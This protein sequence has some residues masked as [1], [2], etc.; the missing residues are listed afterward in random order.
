MS[1]H[2]S[3]ALVAGFL[4][5]TDSPGG[6]SALLKS[7]PSAAGFWSHGRMTDR[8][9]RFQSGMT[10]E[11]LTAFHG[12]ALL[13]WFLADSRAKT[14]ARAIPTP[15]ASVGPGADSGEKWPESLAKFDPCTSS[16][17]TRPSSPAA[18][19]TSSLE[20]LPAWGMMHGGELWAVSTS[21][22]YTVACARGL[23]LPTPLASDGKGSHSMKGGRLRS[24]ARSKDGARN[25]RDWCGMFW[26]MQYPP[27]AAGEYVMGWPIGWTALAPLETARTL[28]RCA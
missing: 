2:F 16:W 22:P 10:F 14:S 18:G 20:T 21:V 5:V 13:T 17:K 12:E 24:A 15:R 8:C 1:W 26:N 9:R 25:W 11:R 19:S 4:A 6:L 3:R 23:L 27:V 7:M 28:E